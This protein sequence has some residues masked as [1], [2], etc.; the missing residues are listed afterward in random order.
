MLRRMMEAGVPR[1]PALLQLCQC[2]WSLEEA[3][4]GVGWWM[5]PL[6]A[7]AEVPPPTGPSEPRASAGVT[8]SPNAG[9]AGVAAPPR[10]A[11]IAAPPKAA[12]ITAPP[13]AA[14]IA[15]PPG[16]AGSA[17][18]PEVGEVGRPMPRTCATQGCRRFKNASTRFCCRDC[19]RRSGTATSQATRAATR[20]MHTRLCDARVER[21]WLAY[22]ENRGVLG[23]RATGHSEEPEREPRQ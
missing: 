10:A 22:P 23:A 15:A 4:L 20:G 2:D 13:E 21:V 8:S 1:R 5:E 12:G 9:A 19:E 6:G 16:A 7:E 17:A 14:G 11:G 18:P 3:L